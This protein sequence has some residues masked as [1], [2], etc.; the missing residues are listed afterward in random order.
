MQQRYI[1]PPELVKG[2]LQSIGKKWRTWK[3][4]L[5]AAYYDMSLP[6]SEAKYHKDERVDEDQW[7]ELWTYW[8]TDEAKVKLL[9]S[10]CL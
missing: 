10:L 7:N 2:T 6:V 8:G 5:K 4:E 9:H 3:A 1:L